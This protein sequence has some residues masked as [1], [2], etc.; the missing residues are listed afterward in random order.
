MWAII[1]IVLLALSP[2]GLP[3]GV[4][5]PVARY[6]LAAY[7]PG[8]T[9]WTRLRRNSS[10][11]V[12]AVFIHHCCQFCRSLGSVWLRSP[13][14]LIFVARVGLRS[15]SHSASDFGSAGAGKYAG[16]W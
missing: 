8:L 16:R 6:L 10:S 15:R 9:I 2:D 7:L 4:I 12:D 3:L 5:R 13:L 1:A 11:L 14:E